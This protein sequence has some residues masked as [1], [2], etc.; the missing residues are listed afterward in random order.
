MSRYKVSHSVL[1]V[2]LERTPGGSQTMSKSP[3]R[4]PQEHPGFLNRGKGA[5]VW[6]VDGNEYVDWV[7][8]LGA[9]PLGYG[10]P[11]VDR[12]IREALDRGLL[13]ASLP[14]PLESEIA[15]R[16]CDIIPCGQDDGQVRFVKTGS[17]ACAA[18]VRIAR[19]ATGRDLVIVVGYHGWHDWVMVTND[20]HPGI[21]DEIAGNE[22]EIVERVPYNDADAIAKI[23]RGGSV[24]AVML[25]PTLLE[26]PNDSYLSD[27]STLCTLH[28]ALCIFDE[29]VTG[30]R[31]A[32][33][34]GQEYFGVT[35]D[36]AVYG[37]GLG[38]GMP[39]ACVI[40]PERFM[41][42]AD[43]ISGTFGGEVLS[44]AAAGAVL[45]AYEKT[46]DGGLLGALPPH[47]PLP[48]F[49]QW[50]HGIWFK[51]ACEKLG[52]PTTGYP[53][54]P[55]IT[56]T[57]RT[58]AVFLQECAKRGLLIHPSGFNVSAALTDEDLQVTYNA[59]KGAKEAL[60]AGVQLEGREPVEGLFKRTGA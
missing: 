3:L 43:V 26:A 36:L 10:H 35:P 14:T 9:V 41:R 11:A 1:E 31:W 46:T 34:G 16:L 54:H 48:I 15:L 42:Y 56:Y 30:F 27:I 59:L 17:E 12:A 58:M 23:M 53:V 2:A 37:K 39:L 5:R 7:C 33:A 40:G 21:P 4:F 28:G 60:D 52:I 49:N 51:H 24:A 50:K 44:L 57:G 22:T 32:R 20:P 29:M 13:S 47:G 25:E 6:D 18:A 19:R 38:N 45:D 55:K 8:G